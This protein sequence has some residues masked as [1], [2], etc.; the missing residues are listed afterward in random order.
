MWFVYAAVG[1]P[2]LMG[3]IL[4]SRYSAHDAIGWSVI[5]MIIGV[6]IVVHVLAD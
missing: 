2:T 5:G 4:G 1:V 6:L 3:G